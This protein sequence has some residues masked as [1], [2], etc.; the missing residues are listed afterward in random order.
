MSDLDSLKEL[1]HAQ[2]AENKEQFSEQRQAT[3]RLAESLSEL[4]SIL[5][6]S[7]ERHLR[8]DDGVKRIGRVLDDHEHRL[9]KAEARGVT[10]AVGW[11]AVTIIGSIVA[12]IVTLGLNHWG[13]K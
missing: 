6:R 7:E 1:M 10:V 13:G 2:R 3:T 4:S 9:R 8:H 11:K 12:T 5:A